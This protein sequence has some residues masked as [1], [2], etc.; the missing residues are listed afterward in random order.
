MPDEK[1]VKAILFD[2]GGTL[3]DSM[4]MYLGPE[5]GWTEV[6][7]VDGA[8]EQVLRL[9]KTWK[10]ALASNAG[11]GEEADIRASLD[12]VGIGRVFHSIITYRM[13]GRPKPWPQ[14]WE[15]ALRQLQVRPENAVMVGDDY[16]ADVWGAV[17]VGMYGIWLNRFTTEIKEGPRV[18]TIHSFE[19]LDAALRSFGFAD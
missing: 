17:D 15:Y 11:E 9:S 6:R 16:M 8:A 2:W 1:P 19:Q 13:A 5:R 3:M 7:P 10:T 14:F 18:R 4:P 12:S